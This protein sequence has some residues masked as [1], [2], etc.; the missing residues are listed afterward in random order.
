M[1]IKCFDDENFKKKKK[2]VSLRKCYFF[3]GIFEIFIH[4]Y[5]KII[6]IFP[7]Y[8]LK[9]PN[10]SFYALIEKIDHLKILI[11]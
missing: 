6:E 1:K 11:D 4:K 5:R 2:L 7:D 9:I 10:I 8:A 3:F